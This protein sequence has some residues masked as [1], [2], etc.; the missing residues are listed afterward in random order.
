MRKLTP[1]SPQEIQRAEEF[2]RKCNPA[3]ANSIVREVAL[4][5]LKSLPLEVRRSPLGEAQK[6]SDD[7]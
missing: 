6:V 2:V 3:L 1:D 4:K 5:V 7:R